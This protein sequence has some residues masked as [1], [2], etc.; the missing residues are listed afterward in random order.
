MLFGCEAFSPFD[1]IG[2]DELDF[3]DQSNT[4]EL[5]VTGGLTTQLAYHRLKI[6][7]PGSILK[8][9]Q[10]QIITDVTPYIISELDTIEYILIDTIGQ[11]FFRTKTITKAELGKSYT[12]CIEYDDKLF[13]AIDSIV[14]VDP[15]EYNSI[16]LPT[17]QRITYG[18]TLE[19]FSLNF[20]KHDFGYAKANVWSW[21]EYSGYEKYNKN[22][23]YLIYESNTTYTHW[24]ADPNAIFSYYSYNTSFAGFKESDT[25]ITAKFSISDGYYQYLLALFSETDWQQGEFAKQRGNLPTNF[26][27]GAAGYFFVSDMHEKHI[28]A[29]DL[30]E[31]IDN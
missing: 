27:E 21:V 11:P 20:E 1:K 9:E 4:I 12:L 17:A 22:N 23:S 7:K 16:K 14:E 19:F 2:L 3:G 15:F 13:T 29:T 8:N 28:V 30:L 5:F 25:L 31:L 26:S 10:S 18:D 6:Q 24:A